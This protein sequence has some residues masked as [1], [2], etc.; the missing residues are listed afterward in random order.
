MD[1]WDA[2]HEQR[3]QPCDFLLLDERGRTRARLPEVMMSG[4][5]CRA[6]SSRLALTNST[7]DPLDERANYDEQLAWFDRFGQMH[8]EPSTE[9]LGAIFSPCICRQCNGRNACALITKRSNAADE[10]VA[11]DLR[12]ADIAHQ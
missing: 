9:R 6:L 8:V 7:P 3:T 4:F 2:I 12:H 1:L 10:F 5:E 11:V